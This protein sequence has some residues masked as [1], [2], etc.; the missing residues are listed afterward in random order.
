MSFGRGRGRGRGGRVQ[1]GPIANDREVFAD[2]QKRASAF[3]ERAGQIYPERSLPRARAVTEAEQLQVQFM[4]EFI[5][6]MQNDTAY[7]IATEDRE[8][9][10]S[11]VGGIG[12][13]TAGSGEGDGI[14]RYSDRWRPK[15]KV[16]YTLQ[17]LHMDETYLPEELLSVVR[18]PD[19]ACMR[20]RHKFDLNKFVD[21]T[22]KREGLEEDAVAG[23]DIQ[24]QSDAESELLEEE[25]D[26][27]DEDGEANDYD[28]NYFSGGEGDGEDAGDGEGDV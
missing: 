3:A 6:S 21:M 11:G 18:G 13:A 22:V 2:L 28:D 7:C 9:D 8:K 27:Y 14:H 26:D 4:T 20:K 19:R 1:A 15:R 5:K 10:A 24:P 25:D 12:G 16:A 17:D 23:A